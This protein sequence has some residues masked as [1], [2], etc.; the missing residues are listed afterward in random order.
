MG[1]LQPDFWR[2]RVHPDDAAAQDL[3]YL[4]FQQGS[5]P[6]YEE[7]YRV[8]HEAGHYISVLARARWV[9]REDQSAGRC[10]LGFA[11]DVTARSADFDRLRAR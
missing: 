8:R 7:I 3:A 9:A 2:S 6:T 10:A 5:A 1:R 4:D 11:I